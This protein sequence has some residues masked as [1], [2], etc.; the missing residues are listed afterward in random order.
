MKRSNFGVVL[1][2]FATGLVLLGTQGADVAQADPPSR[3][4]V[5]DPSDP[6]SPLADP[7]PVP[8]KRA[9]AVHASAGAKISV[10]P[11][12]TFE[13]SG[14]C[15]TGMLEVE[16]DYCPFVE[17]KCLRW[18]DPETKMRCAEFAPSTKCA[19][20]GVH[21]KF[22]IDRYEY[23]NKPG[24]KPVIMKT[25]YEARDT[26]QS[27]GKRLCGES[28]WTL[29]CE[30]QEHLP[31]PY[32]YQRNAE[33]CNI[34]KPHPDVNEKALADPRLRD[35][36]VERLWQGEPSGTREACVSPYGVHDM[37]GN[38]DEWVV[39]ESG[40]PFKSGLKGGYWGPVRTRCRPMTTAHNE[41]FSFYQIGFRCCSDDKG[42][43]PPAGKASE[44]AGAAPSINRAPPPA[45]APAAAG[46]LTGT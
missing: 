39:N 41:E 40:H 7:G 8:E 34:D 22:C 10:T 23:P 21:K 43:P 4:A 17:Q 30:G 13:T 33:A 6:A 28:E 24:E 37:T 16:G 1:F 20:K 42:T 2:G 31:Y 27:V 45:S 35:A 18:L 5:T 38:V 25:W 29:A 12:P 9:D 15:P 36:E 26:C 32:G 3:P 11:T 46:A 14:S 44:P 19:N